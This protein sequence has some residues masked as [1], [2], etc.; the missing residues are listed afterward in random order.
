MP[1]T[2]G[3]DGIRVGGQL[4]RG[5]G[6]HKSC[7]SDRIPIEPL[8]D[9]GR[10]WVDI[11]G[12]LQTLSSTCLFQQLYA[13]ACGKESVSTGGIP[14]WKRVSL[15]QHEELEHTGA[16][17]IRTMHGE[18]AVCRSRE[19]VEGITRDEGH[20]ACPSIA[21]QGVTLPIALPVPPTVPT[22]C[23]WLGQGWPLTQRK[24]MCE[25]ARNLCRKRWATSIKFFS[26]AGRQAG[27]KGRIPQW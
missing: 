8:S 18:K 4:T 2:I 5:P 25:L 14:P 11:V 6:S 16:S 17:T 19:R 3:G 7:G 1:W 21:P 24:L 12:R 22:G 9:W 27:S 20:Q 13:P 10:A 23:R 26:F 15:W